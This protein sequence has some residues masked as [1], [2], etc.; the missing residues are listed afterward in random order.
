MDSQEIGNS[1]QVASSIVSEATKGTE[2]TFK[3]SGE[4]SGEDAPKSPWARYIL[5]LAHGYS[6]ITA[7]QRSGITG[8]E[9]AE[10]RRD[11]QCAQLELASLR[12]A[13]TGD[14][15]AITRIL[16]QS[17]GPNMILDAIEESR[18]RDGV[19]ARDRLG[20]RRTVLEAARILGSSAQQPSVTI[21]ASQAAVL[22]QQMQGPVPRPD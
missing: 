9:L 2:A 7:I 1:I 18:D 13:A 15:S 14:L 12:V 3:V 5:D 6:K 16:A 17:A 21:N 10:A 22:I 11:P 4:V 20:N 8:S 19:S